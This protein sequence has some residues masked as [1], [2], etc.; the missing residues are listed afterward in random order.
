MWPV[1]TD[2]SVVVMG[3]MGLALLGLSRAAPRS[4]EPPSVV[5]SHVIM[6]VKKKGARWAPFFLYWW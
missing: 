1:N 2:F 3:G 5:R 6:R 4:D